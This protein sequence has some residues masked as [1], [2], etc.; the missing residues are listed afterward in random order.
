M[1]A[2][3]KAGLAEK[4]SH[5]STGGGASLE[6]LEGQVRFLAPHSSPSFCTH[7]FSCLAPVKPRPPSSRDV[8]SS[9]REFV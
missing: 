8:C 6:L 4:M 1:A 5:I 7:F 9:P 2:V 3:E